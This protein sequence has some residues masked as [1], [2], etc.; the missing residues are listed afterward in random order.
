MNIQPIYVLTSIFV[1]VAAV[2]AIADLALTD[3]EQKTINVNDDMYIPVSSSGML[4]SILSANDIHIPAACGGKAACGHCKV[5]VKSGGG[6]MLPTEEAF[7]SPKEEERGVRLACQ[8]KVNED[9]K[10]HVKPELLEVEEYTAEVE[11]IRDVTPT[12]KHVRLKMIKPT[13]IE[14]EA[15]QYAQLL[16]PGFDVF[17]AYSI[18]SPPSMA[19]DEDALQFTIKLVPGG[20]CTSWIHFALEEGDTVKFTG[21]YGHFYLD[22]ESDRDII[23]IGGGAGMAPMRG[24]LERLDELGMPRPTRYYFGA[25]NSDELYY[26]DRFAE[27]E[28]QYD[29]FE[30]IPAL[31]DPTPEDQKNW[32]GPFGFVTDVIDEREGSLE[33]TESY[34][35]GPPVMLDA[36][37]RIL[38]DHGMPKE[39]VMFD[40]F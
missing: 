9:M 19:R 39:K 27:L 36:A 2:L 8:V 18:A 32:D 35:C 40:K 13:E 14:F 31:S 12:V 26:E 20:L 29:N 37:E 25:R 3:Q 34:L 16:V 15:G 7:I 1:G 21:P 28:E 5:E 22:E 38:V 6:D 24:I 33:N 4:L 30:Y 23:L 11:E 17:R 10:I